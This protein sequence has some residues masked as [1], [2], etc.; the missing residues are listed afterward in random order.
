MQGYNS[1]YW[2][3]KKAMVEVLWSQKGILRQLKYQGRWQ[4]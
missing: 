2:G 1:G 4:K 3:R